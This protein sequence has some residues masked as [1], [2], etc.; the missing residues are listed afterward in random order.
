M[1]AIRFQDAV[2][3]AIPRRK[4]NRLV[5]SNSANAT[6]TINPDYKEPEEL[7]TESLRVQQQLLDDET[8]TLQ[9][10]ICYLNFECFSLSCGSSVNLIAWVLEN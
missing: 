10:I 7:Q 1:R 6:K 4:F 5:N 2:N 8:R 9:V 3:K